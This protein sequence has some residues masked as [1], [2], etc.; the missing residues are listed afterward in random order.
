MDLHSQI[1]SAWHD[2]ARDLASNKTM[3]LLKP[4]PMIPWSL[5]GCRSGSSP[6]TSGQSMSASTSILASKA[7]FTTS[8]CTSIADRS[9]NYRTFD[10]KSTIAGIFAEPITFVLSQ[11]DRNRRVSDRLITEL[12]PLEGHAKLKSYHAIKPAAIAITIAI[13]FSD[14]AIKRAK[15]H[16][17]ASQLQCCVH[18]GL[19]RSEFLQ[20][21]L[22]P[23]CESASQTIAATPLHLP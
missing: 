2:R 21:E 4:A 8:W 9:D 3:L 12:S 14:R 1:S 18:C 22:K 11:D 7:K 5:M 16:I 10:R 19:H 13:A 23:Q 15:H 20:R 6:Q 17:V